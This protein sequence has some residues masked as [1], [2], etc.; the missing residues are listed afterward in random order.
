MPGPVLGGGT[1]GG[2][3]ALALLSQSSRSRGKHTHR[4]V[5]GI[6]KN[7]KQEK[8]P[9]GN[10]QKMKK[11]LGLGGQEASPGAVSDIWMKGVLG[12]GK[13]SRKVLARRQGD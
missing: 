12:R 9:G 7:G 8:C 2:H 10:K 5:N 3:T 1:G 6:I 4:T 11:I 13:G